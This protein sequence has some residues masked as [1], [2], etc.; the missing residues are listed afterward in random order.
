MEC[1][2]GAQF[3]QTKISSSRHSV[4]MKIIVFCLLATVMGVCVSAHGGSSIDSMS[5]TNHSPWGGARVHSDQHEVN[6]CVKPV[7]EAVLQV[8]TNTKFNKD[9]L[10]DGMRFMKLDGLV[11]K[12]PALQKAIDTVGTPLDHFKKL[13]GCAMENPITMDMACNAKV[14]FPVA[15]KIKTDSKIH[16]MIKHGIEISMWLDVLLRAV[17][18]DRNVLIGLSENFEQ[19]ANSKEGKKARKGWH[20]FAKAKLWAVRITVKE[21]LASINKQRID[22]AEMRGM[23]NGIPLNI[24]E[25]VCCVDAVRFVPH[26][27]CDVMC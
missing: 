13:A 26:F 16:K 4:T 18:E 17:I 27:T 9:N 11:A 5:S 23:N 12:S 21:I 3:I 25:Y 22:P 1:R 8:V 24:V 19:L 15:E 20:V 14:N 2:F 7:Y 10:M 6:S